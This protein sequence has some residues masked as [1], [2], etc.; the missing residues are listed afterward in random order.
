MFSAA[1]LNSAGLAVLPANGGGVDLAPRVTALSELTH[2]DARQGRIVELRYFGGLSEEEV[3][4]VL[5]VS[6]R[7]VTREWRAARA[8][9]YRRMTV[10]PNR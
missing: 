9:L 6:R 8:W 7:T 4:T 5:S 3:A 10:R 1:L 2:L